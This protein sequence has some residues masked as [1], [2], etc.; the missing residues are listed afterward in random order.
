[1]IKQTSI[2]AV[3]S[4]IV[5]TDVI[6]HFITLKK[7]G[8]NYTACCPF[9]DERTPSFVVSPAKD[10]YK[11]FGCGKSG[12]AFTFIKDHEHKSYPEAIEWLA[13]FYNITIEYDQ[14]TQQQSEEIK[15]A[16]AQMQQVTSF[17]H[18]SY[19]KALRSLPPDAAV[20]QYLQGRGY[21]KQRCEA[22]SLGFAPDDWKY[23]TTPLINMGKYQPALDCGIVQTKSG[24]NWDFF[25]NRII[26]PI[27]DHNGILVGLAG[28]S[29]PGSSLTADSSQP[30]YLNP[31]ES[32]LY[33]KKNIWYGLWQAQKAIRQ[34]GFAYIVEGYFD[35]QA[36]HDAG[37]LNTIAPCGTGIDL[38]QLKFLKRYC[39]HLVLATDGDSAGQKA[40][41]K[42]I[43][44][45][46]QLD[47]KTQVLAL[48]D[49]MDPDEYIRSINEKTLAA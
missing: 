18:E 48:P 7:H 30:K 19:A 27:H 20:I 16:K 13:S 25:R 2:D 6:G 10:I 14:Q 23:L 33:Q 21:D 47:F 37:I 1:L 4:H 44:L 12:D 49:A 28:R 43:D 42:T 46:L 29:V 31:P 26:I 32:L 8:A 5:L 45:C 17:A 11:C 40:M 41:L 9:H 35:V 22:W 3:R 39:N 24:N 34:T 36:M 15:D 38:L